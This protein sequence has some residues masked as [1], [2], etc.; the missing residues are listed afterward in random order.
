MPS[1][2][3]WPGVGA[4]LRAL[5]RV[6][7]RYL[8]RP[9]VPPLPPARGPLPLDVFAAESSQGLWAGAASADITPPEVTRSWVAGFAP[10]RRCTGLRDPLFARCLVL[11]AGQVPLVLISLDLI[12]LFAN[13]VERLRGLISR[14]HP[15]A[16]WITCTHNHQSPYTLGLRGP[17]LA[18]RIP[19]RSGVD[20]EYMDVLELRVVGMVEAALAAARP[21]RMHT[22][23]GDFDR[24]GKWVHNERS[25]VLDREM[26]VLQVDGLDDRSIATL[27]QHACHPETLWDDNT[28]MSADFPAV[29]CQTVEEQLGGT[30]LFFNGALG[31]MV[32][33]AVGPNTP[34]AFRGELLETLG[35]R[36]GQSALRLA[37]RARRAEP[38]EAVIRTALGRLVLPAEDNRLVSFLLALGVIEG[39]SVEGGLKSEVGLARLGSLI[40]LA[41]PGEPAPELALELL[42]RLPGRQHMLLGLANDELGYLLPPEFFHDPAYAYERGMSPGPMAA[43]RIALALERLLELDSGA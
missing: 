26:R 13:R 6:G 10:G 9:Q 33:A 35:K 22:A 11:R 21:A 31:A 27:V 17:A 3:R 43:T 18:H 32:S 2:W 39:R 38:L 19:I 28:L 15:S 29:C 40:L 34:L 25:A 7:D 1:F 30:A 20:P 4:V 36:M 41:L 8:P 14:D 24:S 23:A 42:A 37:R 16:V 12:G 5:D